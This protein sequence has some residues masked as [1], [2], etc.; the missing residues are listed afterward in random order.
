M[1]RFN[2]ITFITHATFFI[3]FVMFNVSLESKDKN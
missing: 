1:T 2:Y 3:V